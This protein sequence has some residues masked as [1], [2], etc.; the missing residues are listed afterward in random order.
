MPLF[1]HQETARKR[2]PSIRE[3]DYPIY[4]VTT[5]DVQHVAAETIGRRLTP[6]ELALIESKYTSDWWDTVEYLIESYT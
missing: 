1:L 5:S 3:I 4:M 6:N 2:K